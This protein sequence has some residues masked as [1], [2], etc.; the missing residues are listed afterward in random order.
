MFFG[1]IILLPILI[2]KGKNTFYIKN[3]LN[4]FIRIVI[5]FGAFV[6]WIYGAGRTSLPSITTI[7]FACPLFV[8]P[9]AYIFL[10]EKSDWYRILSVIIGFLG[11]III[12]FFENDSNNISSGFSLHIG[13]IFLFC[14][15]ILFAISDILNKKMISSES[16]LSLLFYF[17][18]GT[19]LIAI[20]PALLVWRQISHLDL[21]YLLLLGI[22]GVTILYCLLKATAATEISSIAPYKYVELIISIIVGYLL[23][24]EI[25]QI[26]TIIGACFIIPG[27]L[28]I[29]YHEFNKERRKS[30]PE[31]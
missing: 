15:A 9:L 26:S 27:A 2:C 23:F 24:H 8:L 25:I 3:K 4:H 22:G 28:L 21:F 10:N 31:P 11:V 12:A 18:L 17:Y 13:V 1:V 30:T 29:A 19:A 20:I 5:G 14:A 16:L 6:C 7:S